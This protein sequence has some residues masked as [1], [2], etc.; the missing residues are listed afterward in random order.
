MSAAKTVL[1]IDDN[2]QQIRII[3]AYAAL[4]KNVDFQFCQSL[5]EAAAAVAETHFDLLFLDNRLHPY[6]SWVD[7]LPVLVDAGYEG[8]T[9]VV[10]A[11]IRQAMRSDKS[12]GE[13]V[14]FV[15]KCELSLSNFPVIV[16]SILAS[17]H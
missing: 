17:T 7:T 12:T 4:L 6:E 10:S 15:D 5:E 13:R 3:Q 14:Q 2:E 8:K 9:V 11:D 1:F 16:K